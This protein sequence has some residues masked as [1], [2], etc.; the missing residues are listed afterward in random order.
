M[1]TLTNEDSEANAITRGITWTGYS[2]PKYDLDGTTDTTTA[3]YQ[4]R[5]LNIA[6]PFDFLYGEVNM[7][8][9]HSGLLPNTSYIITFDV[10]TADPSTAYPWT[11]SVTGSWATSFTTDEFGVGETAET[12]LSATRGTA[13]RYVNPVV[14]LAP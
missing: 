9:Q 8:W 3:T 2:F 11:Y 12:V 5:E 10:E 6:T 14:T 7:S 4:A 13:K 1:E